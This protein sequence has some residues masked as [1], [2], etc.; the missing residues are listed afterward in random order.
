MSLG[1]I[2]RAL[3]LCTLRPSQ[4]CRVDLFAMETK[5]I[6]ASGRAFLERMAAEL[7]STLQRRLRRAFPRTPDDFIVDA[8]EDAL[9]EYAA[10]PDRH[11]SCDAERAHLYRA[12]WRNVAN[13][14]DAERRRRTRDTQYATLLASE[15]G[16]VRPSFADL[17]DH[18]STDKRLDGLATNPAEKIALLLWLNGER[19][20]DALAKALGF[21]TLSVRAQRQEVKRFKDR[22]SKRAERSANESQR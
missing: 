1:V 15:H 17:D 20:S 10:G 11:L 16:L 2:A 18:S 7:L 21:S 5:A 9:L 4:R 14:V 12:S 19:H 8:V 6:S 13:L 3:Y 22:I